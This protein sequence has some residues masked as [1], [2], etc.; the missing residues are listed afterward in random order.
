MRHYSKFNV[1]AESTSI[2]KL[3]MQVVSVPCYH[4]GKVTVVPVPQ[5]CV[6]WEKIAE[7]YRLA[8]ERLTLKIDQMIIDIDVMGTSSN[9]IRE[10]LENEWLSWL[11]DM[12]KRFEG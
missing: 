10:Y 4:C 11:K 12:R 6:D 9:P 1:M 7:E 2:P 5:D 3:G 8:L